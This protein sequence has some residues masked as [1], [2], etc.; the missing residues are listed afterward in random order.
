MKMV[1]AALMLLASTNA[2]ALCFS[3]GPKELPEVTAGIPTE[4]CLDQLFIN[5]ENES[6]SATS[7]SSQYIF[8]GLNVISLT[9]DN[10]NYFFTASNLIFE[11][12]SSQSGQRIKI[13]LNMKGM[14][15]FSGSSDLNDLKISIR[16]QMTSRKDPVS[17]YVKIF[18]YKVREF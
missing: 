3:L 10:E 17:S 2:L 7:F 14:V 9:P 6:I 5:P 12:W 15:S 16:K 1:I 4:I 13:E 8:D 11:S 18:E